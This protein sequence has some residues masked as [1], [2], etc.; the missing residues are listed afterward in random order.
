MVYSERKNRLVHLL[1]VDIC[2]F[3]NG[4]SIALQSVL[5]ANNS[6]LCATEKIIVT[7]K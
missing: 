6:F 4:G 3:V 7:S 2:L 1:M 5:S